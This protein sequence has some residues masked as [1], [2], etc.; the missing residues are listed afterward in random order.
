MGSFQS[1]N[2]PSETEKGEKIERKATESVGRPTFVLKKGML[3][4]T[5]EIPGELVSFQKVELY[6]KV[7]S[8]VKKIYVDVGSQVSRGQL[9]ATMEA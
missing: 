5:L 9:L 4:S 3:S 8:F 1:C 6:A 2:N 7:N